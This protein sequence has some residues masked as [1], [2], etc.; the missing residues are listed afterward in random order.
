MITPHASV[1]FKFNQEATA[2]LKTNV[3]SILK[4][5][6]EQ[7]PENGGPWFND[8]AAEDS[9][10]FQ[11]SPPALQ[12]T[13]FLNG[14]GLTKIHVQMFMYK[15]RVRG[16]IIENP[17]IDTPGL[18]PLPGRFNVL[19]DGNENSKMHWWNRSVTDSAIG[20]SEIP[21]FG[22]RWQ[23][24]GDS[25]EEQFDRLGPPDYSADGLS[26]ID[27]TGDFVRTEIVHSIERT[28]DR[29]VVISTRI[30]HPWEEILEKV[31]NA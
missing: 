8:P 19:F 30:R 29:R 25:R 24:L 12:I 27:Q 10:L 14:L 13:E 3:P 26:K 23:V 2:W 17:H 20:V 4:V 6:D 15:P 9:I 31:K 11:S 18:W 7:F 16:M 5:F 22:R 28:G 1:N 21:G